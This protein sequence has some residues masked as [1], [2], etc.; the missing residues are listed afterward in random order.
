M[1]YN[2]IMS[3]DKACNSQNGALRA[4]AKRGSRAMGS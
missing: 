1:Q 4:L 2:A 3:L